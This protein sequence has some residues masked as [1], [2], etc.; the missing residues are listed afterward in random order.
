MVHDVEKSEHT[1]HHEEQ[2]ICMSLFAISAMLKE[3][4][5]LNWL[6]QSMK[7]N[8]ERWGFLWLFCNCF[9]VEMI[10]LI[11]NVGTVGLLCNYHSSNACVSQYKT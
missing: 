1:F 11:R 10:T 6:W 9:L 5:T 4:P 3:V 8:S 7:I 2:Q